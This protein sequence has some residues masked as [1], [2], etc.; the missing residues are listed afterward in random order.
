M[1]KSGFTIVELIL[2]MGLFSIFITVLTSIFISILDVQT[3]SESTSSVQ[4]DSRF[5]FSRMIYDIHRAS[6][7]N[8]PASAGQTSQSLTLVIGGSTYTYAL[9]GEALTL[10]VD[11]VTE[12]L[13]GYATQVSGF[14]VTRIGNPTGKHT[15]S[16][17]MT[18]TDQTESKSYQIT[19]GLR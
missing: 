18:V 6:T 1:K 2:Y 16:L 11:G 5:L 7:I 13:S 4:Q 8:T 17:N 19:V 14:S 3:K 12:S 15:L 9:T 10:T